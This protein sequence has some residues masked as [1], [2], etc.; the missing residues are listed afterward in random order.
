MRAKGSRLKLALIDIPMGLPSGTGPMRLCES[1]AR[2]LLG[3][4]KSSV[5]P[6]PVRSAV[7]ELGGPEAASLVN[8]RLT[9]KKI[10]RQSWN[11][12]PKIREA[13]IFLR[14]HPR[15]RG[16]TRESHPEL[17]FAALN[18]GRPLPKPKKHPLGLKHRR[19]LLE[20]FWPLPGKAFKEFSRRFPGTAAEDDVLDAIVLAVSARLIESEGQPE[21]LPAEPAKD[22]CGLA[23][24]IVFPRPFAVKRR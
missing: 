24:R 2:N 6:V 4:R 16:R 8:F 10:S 3:P 7:Y 11:L 22:E 21:T 14:R 5:F 15:L 20:E 9:G 1:L 18:A 19:R 13:D 17:C 12:F 23:M